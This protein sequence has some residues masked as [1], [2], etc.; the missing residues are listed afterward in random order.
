MFHF[1]HK[2]ALVTGGSRGIGRS[3]AEVFASQGIKVACTARSS[4]L[5]E[6]SISEMKAKSLDVM[7]FVCD[8]TDENQV[9]QTYQEICTHLGV[10]TVLVH[11]AGIVEEK[12]ILRLNSEEWDKMIDVHLKASF[13]WSKI[14]LR[15]MV[16]QKKGRLIFISS[17]LG[18][19]GAPALSHYAAS[20]SGMI[21]LAK[22]IA[23]EVG[24]KN[25]TSNVIAPGY[26]DTQMILDKRDEVIEIINKKACIKRIG[27]PR[28]IANLALYLIST[29]ASY[30]TGQVITVDGGISL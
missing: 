20:K 26:I 13:L 10:P 18:L 17:I 25:I 30:I 22:S 4:S 7:G 11:N 2:V 16:Q 24:K 23:Q 3:I 6:N 19:K 1:D 8:G 27:E 12:I 5:L 28:D 29:E 15:G 14:S 9:K 21:G